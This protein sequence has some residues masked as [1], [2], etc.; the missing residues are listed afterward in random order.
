MI[1][2]KKWYDNGP[3]IYKYREGIVVRAPD[4]QSYQLM[5]DYIP[6]IASAIWG[7]RVDD[8]QQYGWVSREEAQLLKST[9]CEIKPVPEDVRCE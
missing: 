4:C 3:S 8:E 9:E 6:L 1:E 2:R 7:Q 5:M